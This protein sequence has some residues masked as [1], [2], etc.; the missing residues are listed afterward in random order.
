MKRRHFQQLLAAG[1][2]CLFLPTRAH[3]ADGAAFPAAEALVRRLLGDA[4][5]RI[6]C[7]KTAGV[8]DA[9]TIDKDGG[10]LVLRGNSPVAIAAALNDWS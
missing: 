10:T 1:S 5:D 4:A 3:A 7:E 8:T 6:R 9:Y 2:A